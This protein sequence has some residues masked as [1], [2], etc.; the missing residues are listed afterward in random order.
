MQGAERIQIRIVNS[1]VDYGNKSLCIYILYL[2]RET[3]ALYVIFI[4]ENIPKGKS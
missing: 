3:V 4:R 1:L 2:L